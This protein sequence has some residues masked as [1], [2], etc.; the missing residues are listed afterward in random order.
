ML[1]KVALRVLYHDVGV[2]QRFRNTAY[3]AHKATSSAAFYGVAYTVFYPRRRIVQTLF[4]PVH[5]FE[6]DVAFAHL[7]SS[8]FFF[9]W[10]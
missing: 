4:K 7:V 3:L 2:L 8:T 5:I 1:F 9:F 10:R 6:G